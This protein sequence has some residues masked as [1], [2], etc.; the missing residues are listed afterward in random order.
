MFSDPDSGHVKNV[1]SHGENPL[2]RA[3]QNGVQE[4]LL[5][6]IESQ[7]FDNFP[8][9]KNADPRKCA[10]FIDGAGSAAAVLRGGKRDGSAAWREARRQCFV[11]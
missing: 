4:T 2:S 7:L 3:L 10:T 9:G 5:F 6:T 11:A 1:V 8:Q